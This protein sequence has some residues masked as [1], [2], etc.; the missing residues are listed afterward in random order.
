M[1]SPFFQLLFVFQNTPAATLSMPGL[2]FGDFS[3]E[4]PPSSK[5]DLTLFLYDGD[6]VIQGAIHYNADIFAAGS[7]RNF[8]ERFQLALTEFADHPSLHLSELLIMAPQQ[9]AAA[10]AGFSAALGAG[11]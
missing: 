8:I 7:I 10:T 4:D 1:A 5:F 2:S 6:S 9:M 11:D 3:V